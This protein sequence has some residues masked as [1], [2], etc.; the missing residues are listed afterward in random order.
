MKMIWSILIVITVLMSQSVIGSCTEHRL[1]HPSSNN[2]AAKKKGTFAALVQ[3][4]PNE[5][6]W[7][8]H[9]FKVHDA[10][11]ETPGNAKAKSDDCT[12][13]CF[14]FKVDG[15][16]PSEVPSE[17]ATDLGFREDSEV[18]WCST[19]MK[20]M[21]WSRMINRVHIG[22]SIPAYMVGKFPVHYIDAAPEQKQIE[23]HICDRN[24]SSFNV[25]DPPQ[26]GEPVLSLRVME[27]K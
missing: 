6:E 21:F 19:W 17:V 26:P 14:T 15:K 11:L 8:G 23:L 3:I 1:T 12:R 18:H 22:G 10:W 20:P 27:S 16:R 5:F 4:T 2:R 7:K 13:F 24:S 9:K 25:K